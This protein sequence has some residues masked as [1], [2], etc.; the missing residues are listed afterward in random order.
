MLQTWTQPTEK[1]IGI[2]KFPNFRLNAL[3]RL[4]QSTLGRSNE[5]IVIDN[6]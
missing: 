2:V 6:K 1:V 4:A 3:T 5:N